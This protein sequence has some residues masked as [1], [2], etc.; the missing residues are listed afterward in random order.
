LLIV[1]PRHVAL[2]FERMFADVVKASMAVLLK[3]VWWWA[4]PGAPG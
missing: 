3:N 2:P 4:L 1:P